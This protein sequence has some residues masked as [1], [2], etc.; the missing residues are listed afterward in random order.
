MVHGFARLESLTITKQKA[1]DISAVPA[2]L[3]I[4]LNE[5]RYRLL[6]A[7]SGVAFA[8]S[9]GLPGNQTSGAPYRANFGAYF[10]TLQSV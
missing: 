5:V 6:A 2:T 4:G 1:V 9:G 10:V 7:K 8:G 3:V